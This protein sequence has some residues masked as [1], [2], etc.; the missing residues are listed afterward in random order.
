MTNLDASQSN[1][2]L[3]SFFLKILYSEFLLRS[4]HPAGQGSDLPS[5]G[6]C[7]DPWL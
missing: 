7:P 4:V 6:R 3:P 1:S 2:T 5:I